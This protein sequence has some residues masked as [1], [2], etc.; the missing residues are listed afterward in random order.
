M[1]LLPESFRPFEFIGLI[2]LS[3][4][5]T[6]KVGECRSLFIF[7]YLRGVF[8]DWLQLSGKSLI[9]FASK[10]D[11]QSLLLHPLV[12]LGES[13]AMLKL[14]NLH[15]L[16]LDG[17][18]HGVDMVGC[19]LATLI[20]GPLGVGIW[21]E[22]LDDLRLADLSAKYTILGLYMIS[23]VDVGNLISNCKD[24]FDLVN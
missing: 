9:N 15:C 6:L 13:F 23:V 12:H 17:S 11:L 8:A 4:N 7:V 22:F 19:Q 18:V 16:V 2:R 5:G 14:A 10:K 24:L 3:F 21:L 1:L 20:F